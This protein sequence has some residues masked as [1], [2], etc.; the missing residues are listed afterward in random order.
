MIS[1]AYEGG[2]WE[3]QHYPPGGIMG[4]QALQDMVKVYQVLPC[5]EK[6]EYD[7]GNLS[8]Q[9]CPHDIPICV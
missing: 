4:N 7:K 6:L 8:S 3:L 5:D 1:V 2:Y 9:I